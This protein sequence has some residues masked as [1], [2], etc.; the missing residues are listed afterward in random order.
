MTTSSGANYPFWDESLWVVAWDRDRPIGMV[1]NFV[2]SEENVHYGRLR[3]YTEYINVARDW[4]RRGVAR[5]L[6]LESFAV[7]ERS[8]M[9]EAALG[10]F[11]HNPTGA[12]QLY[13][14]LGFRAVRSLIAHRKPMLA[15]FD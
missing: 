15:T 11:V 5:A 12:R 6:I 10:V 4:R 14:S 2:K 13:E 8:G 1:L 9:N 3:G 7:L